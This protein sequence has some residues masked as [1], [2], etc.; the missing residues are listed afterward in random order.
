MILSTISRVNGEFSFSDVVATSPEMARDFVTSAARVPEN[1][2][3]LFRDCAIAAGKTS[4]MV[5]GQHPYRV[6][7]EIFDEHGARDTLG[8]LWHVDATR[9]YGL[10]VN[11]PRITTLE[12]RAVQLRRLVAVHLATARRTYGSTGKDEAWI[13]PGGKIL[14]ASSATKGHHEELS[15]RVRAIEAFKRAADRAEEEDAI[16]RWKALVSGRWSLVEVFESDGKR[17]FVARRNPP[18]LGRHLALT[19]TEELVLKLVGL[20]QSQRLIAY[21]L[22]ISEGAVSMHLRGAAFKMGI[23]SR[24]AL[25]ALGK[26]AVEDRVDADALK[27]RSAPPISP[28]GRSPRPEPGRSRARSRSGSAGPG[29]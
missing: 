3:R 2:R 23:R 4:S 14:D 18:E 6:A 8:L 11:L 19:R 24:S 15:L 9:L 1:W 27:S 28:S 29:E 20:G 17:M 5:F 10:F 25:L 13:D 26:L 21:S 7:R 12:R 22:G 16:V